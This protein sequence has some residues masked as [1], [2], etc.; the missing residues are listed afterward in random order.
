MSAFHAP[1]TTRS[2]L[3]P[4]RAIVRHLS[5]PSRPTSHA[6]FGTA[7]SNINNAPGCQTCVVAAESP[8]ATMHLLALAYLASFLSFVA[9]AT[10]KRTVPEG[11]VTTNGQ[12]F[13]LDGEP[14]VSLDFFCRAVGI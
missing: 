3:P 1:S 9:T 14:F 11:F 8:F 7:R 10:Q 13:E 12:A 4:D 2:A 5:L 6:Q